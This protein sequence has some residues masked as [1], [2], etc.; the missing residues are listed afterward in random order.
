MWRMGCECDLP[1]R[2]DNVYGGKVK[3]RSSYTWR[4]HCSSLIQM[5]KGHDFLP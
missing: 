1:G 2:D 4:L 5:L 3:G